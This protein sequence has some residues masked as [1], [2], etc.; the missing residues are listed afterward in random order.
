MVELKKIS[1]VEY[2]IPKTGEMNVV[3]R[4]LPDKHRVFKLL[5]L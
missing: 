1:S 3:G 4:I 5:I 2:E